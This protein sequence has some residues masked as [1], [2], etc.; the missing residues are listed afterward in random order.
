MNTEHAMPWFKYSPAEWLLNPAVRELSLPQ[1]GILIE[2]LCLDWINHGVPATAKA[3]RQL[4]R[5]DAR[6]ESVAVVLRL[7]TVPVGDGKVS[8]PWLAVQR[9]QAHERLIR[10]SKGGVARHRASMRQ[11][12]PTGCHAHAQKTEEEGEQ[13]S[14][15]LETET[16][17]CSSFLS[18][19]GALPDTE[20]AAIDAARVTGAPESF[21]RELYHQLQ[22][23]GWV[24]A[25]GRPVVDWLSY[26]RKSDM[27]R[28]KEKPIKKSGYDGIK[29]TVGICGNLTAAELNDKHTKG[30]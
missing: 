21:I 15:S 24:D 9:R 25:S 3:A 26:V 8:H 17:D 10:A 20:Q 13:K 6:S 18:P 27:K 5:G 14:P 28:A 23:V 7:F 16:P 29:K 30:F 11:A 22:A 19:C 4:I 1:R 12:A 2:L